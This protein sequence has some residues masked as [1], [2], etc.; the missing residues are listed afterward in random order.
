MQF[1]I[2]LCGACISETHV[3]VCVFC[4]AER[5]VIR[6]DADHTASGPIQLRRL[7]VHRVK[8]SRTDDFGEPVD[9]VLAPGPAVQFPIGK[10]HAQ[11]TDVVVVRR[12]RR[13]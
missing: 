6:V 5:N 10:R 3:R 12:L 1:D 8:R 4:A 7:R 11:R 9:R 2:P 13:R